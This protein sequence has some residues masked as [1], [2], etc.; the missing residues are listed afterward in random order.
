MEHAD[1][2]ERRA[3]RVGADL[4]ECGLGAL[5]DR[6]DAGDY[7]D[8]AARVD[9][10]AHAVERAKPALL[11]EHA[12]AEPDQLPC[13]P[14]FS[15]R[16]FELVVTQVVEHALQQTRV[17]TEVVGDLGAERVDRAGERHSLGRD[18]VG[19]AHFDR[20]VAEAV[21]DRV[22][23]A[24][25]HERALVAPRRAIG[26][27]R[28]LVGQPDVTG[29]PIGRYDIGAGQHGRGQ[30]RDRGGVGPDVGALVRPEFDLEA[31][32]E[33]ARI[34]RS[35]HLV[36]LIARVVGRDQMLAAVLDPFDRPAQAARG[37]T[38][39]HVLG[40]ELAA[41]AE[42][43]ADVPL[44]QLQPAG[45]QIE[46]RGDGIAVV[47]RH[48]G[49]AVHLQ[50][51]TAGVVASDRAAR[52]ERHAA[53]PADRELEL[54]H[55]VGLAER[56]IEIAVAFADRRRL[57]RDAGSELARRRGGTDDRRQLLDL[58]RHQLGG[59]LCEIGV[60]G[61]HAGD[62]LADV[63]DELARE[64]RLTVGLQPR[65]PGHAE[66]DRRHLGDIRAGPHRDHARSAERRAD[67]DVA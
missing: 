52:L 25:A 11:D 28:G 24:L 60:L 59:V 7:L 14:A 34:D 51:I 23:Q 43:A 32:D 30:I 56:L 20:V 48:L 64:D 13:P 22:D 46:H 21:R 41:D 29:R 67:V 15:Q 53:V 3:Q 36:H 55:R 54:D 63:A 66:I 42:T 1:V 12:E 33:A 49:G 10:D 31:E 19:P 44:E 62:R 27:G 17:V 37:E 47:M 50:T 16:R 39:Q 57:A 4:G 9:G 40:I 8:P 6:G 65:D 2:I 45:G 5:A 26:P 61:E 18:Q 58:E 38:D 35:A